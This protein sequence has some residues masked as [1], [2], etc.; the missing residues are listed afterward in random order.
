MTARTPDDI[1]EEALLKHAAA[2]LKRMGIKTASAA[3]K[4]AGVLRADPVKIAEADKPA[5]E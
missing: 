3:F 4:G 1:A 5:A 2:A